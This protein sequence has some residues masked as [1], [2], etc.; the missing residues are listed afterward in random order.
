MTVTNMSE[1]I[2]TRANKAFEKWSDAR[3]QTRYTML[4][5]AE[6]GNTDITDTT[7]V[8]PR[9]SFPNGYDPDHHPED[10]REAILAE[11][12]RRGVTLVSP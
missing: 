10:N 3:L 7:Q 9:Q 11:A 2:S 6:D 1:F 12:T 8:I 5:Y 4:K